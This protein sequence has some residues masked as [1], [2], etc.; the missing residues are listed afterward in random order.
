MDL[1]L[2]F[3]V[4]R[5][6]ASEHPDKEGVPIILALVDVAEEI[7]SKLERIA[8]AAERSA[9][10]VMDNGPNSLPAIQV[11]DWNA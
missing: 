11:R 1:K 8:V 10:T 6:A 9:D 4:I 2:A 3:T 5:K 7:M